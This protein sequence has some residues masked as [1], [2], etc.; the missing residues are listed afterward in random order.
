M[1]HFQI[2]KDLR[3]VEGTTCFSKMLQGKGSRSDRTRTTWGQLLAAATPMVQEGGWGSYPPGCTDP[4]LPLPVT[5]KVS[6]RPP[7]HAGGC[8]FSAAIG[9]RD[10]CPQSHGEDAAS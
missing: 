8:S 10:I 2:N 7:L 6:R 5:G 1:V 9:A 4:G 3:L